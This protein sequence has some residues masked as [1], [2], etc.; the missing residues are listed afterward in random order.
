MADPR[1][2]PA[3]ALC[4][5]AAWG[6]ALTAFSAEPA[7]EL[8]VRYD[9]ERRSLDGS[10]ELTVT[11]TAPTLY[12]S[13]L[14]N[15]ERDRNPHLSAR[16][17]DAQYPFGFETSETTV[18]TVTS[19]AGETETALD[20][21]LLAFPPSWQ[22][23]SLEAG[24]LAIDLPGSLVEAEAPLT[25]RIE[26]VTDIPRNTIGDQG[27]TAGILTWRFGWFP[28]LLPEQ[29]EIVEVDGAVAYAERSA[30]PLAFSWVRF[31]ANVT[32]PVEM[33]VLSGADT[34]DVLHLEESDEPS[35]EKT[36]RLVFDSPAR[37]SHLPS[38][39]TTAAT[40][41]KDRPRLR[42]HTCPA[43][44]RRRGSWRPWHRTSSPSSRRATVRILARR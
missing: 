9:V 29:D 38:G 35:D 20:F 10:V 3:I 6:I 43:T 15:L 37:S 8:D 13:L 44:R 18:L 41:S 36:V 4:I 16:A 2:L 23:Y 34:V 28:T 7:Y 25:V 42:R 26:F 1:K 22:T 39:R 11:P 33:D 40:R 27:M 5:L 24:V 31:E 17:A 14:A 21:R 30:F 19:I 32:V 12:L